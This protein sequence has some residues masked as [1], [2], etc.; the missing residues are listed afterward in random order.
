MMHN[1]DKPII[2]HIPNFLDYCEV[3]KGLRDNTQKNYS[4]YLN[5]FEKWLTHTGETTKLPHQLTAEDVWNYRL[6]LARRYQTKKK[7]TLS[8]KSQNYY[9]IA[10]R[11]LLDYFTDRDINSLPASKIKLAKDTHSN[12][13]KFLTLEQVERLLRVPKVATK[14][15][16]RDR[17][18]METL[19]STGLR[20]SELVSLNREQIHFRDPDGLEL[21]IQGK[22]GSIRTV[23]FSPRA[24]Y[25]VK[26]YLETRQNDMEPALFINYQTKNEEERRLNQRSVQSNIKKY[27]RLAGIP[28]SVTPHVLR[29]SY[30][31]DLLVQGVDLRTVQEFLGH[32][33]VATT[34]IYTHITSKRLKEIHSKFHG[35]NKLDKK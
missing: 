28:I 30:A 20:V 4:R 21:T 26:K 19:F 12:S 11:S 2:K 33:N 17:A 14:V 8:K 27:S 5:V 6:F 22:G 24:L 9:L 18:I 25:W 16:L 13:V 29:H 3:E 31:T 23:Y 32:K 34:Q 35:G 15:G 7:K 10:L 1:S